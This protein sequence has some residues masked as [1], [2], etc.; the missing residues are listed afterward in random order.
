MFGVKVVIT[1]SEM[2]KKKTKK[3]KRTGESRSS[4]IRSS[5]RKFSTAQTEKP[6]L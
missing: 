6:R 5:Q 1:A 4:S 2:L 3:G